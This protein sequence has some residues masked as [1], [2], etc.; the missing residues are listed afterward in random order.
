MK[1]K[2]G[3]TLI[4]LVITIIVLLI[5]AGVSITM[6]S[7]EN[8]ILKKASNSKVETRGA[9]VQ[10]IRDLWKSEKEADEVIGTSDSRTL[11]QVLE[12]LE[13]QKLITSE[14]RVMIEKHGHVVIGTRDISFLDGIENS[15]Y[16]IVSSNDEIEF[17]NTIKE[18]NIASEKPNYTSYKVEGVSTSKDGE[19]VTSGSVTGKSGNLEIIG[20][21]SNTTF[22][23]ILSDF[24]QGDEIFYIKI[25]IDGEKYYQEL[26]VIQGDKVTYE[27]DFLKIS[28]SGSTEIEE[29]ENFSSGSALKMLSS[30]SSTGTAEFSFTGSAMEFL[31]IAKKEEQATAIF[32]VTDTNGNVKANVPSIY[33]AEEEIEYNVKFPHIEL[34]KNDIYLVTLSLIPSR[35]YESEG[36]PIITTYLYFDAVVIYK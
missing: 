29:N 36:N 26:S 7:G 2:N 25:D 14:E 18:G 34:E 4:A 32:K 31:T 19:F 13:S 3:I 11:D 23:Y 8:G 28:Y 10:E 9:S 30:E 27:E 5:L 33:D 35:D 17:K 12:E 16:T 21:I 6:I 24:M 22:K 20:E 15:K 1:K